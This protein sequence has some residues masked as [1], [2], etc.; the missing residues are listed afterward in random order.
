MVGRPW[1]LICSAALTALT[2]LKEVQL[3]YWE[4]VRPGAWRLSCLTA[5]TKLSIAAERSDS[6]HTAADMRAAS[7]IGLK[8]VQTLMSGLYSL[9][10]LE[11]RFNCSTEHIPELIATAIK[12]PRPEGVVIFGP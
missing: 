8:E 3:V 9:Q 10:C 12:L 11:L 4:E 7:L 5:L 6:L 2:G 1:L